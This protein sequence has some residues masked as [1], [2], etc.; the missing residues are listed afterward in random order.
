MNTIVNFPQKSTNVI[1][2]NEV[3]GPNP[4]RRFSMTELHFDEPATI[5]ITP[6]WNRPDTIEVSI[7]AGDYLKFVH[8]ELGTATI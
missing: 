5:K 3:I 7:P 8:L 1:D 4:V 2:P 6:R